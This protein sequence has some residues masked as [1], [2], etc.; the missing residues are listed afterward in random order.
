[1]SGYT[2]TFVNLNGVVDRCVSLIEKP[3]SR[4]ILLRAL[5]EVLE[6]QVEVRLT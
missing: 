6:S 5:R 4:Q 2:G 1:M 3:F